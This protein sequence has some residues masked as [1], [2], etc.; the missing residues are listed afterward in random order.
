MYLSGTYGTLNE[1]RLD[2]GYSAADT[3][4]N[5]NDSKASFVASAVTAAIAFATASATAPTTDVAAAATCTATSTVNTTD[6]GTG[7]DFLA[8][9]TAAVATGMRGARARQGEGYE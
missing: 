3:V 2:V 7:V 6:S 5:T 1:E 8:L 9:T 4:A